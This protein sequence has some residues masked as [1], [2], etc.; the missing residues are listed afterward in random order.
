VPALLAH[1]RPV[2]VRPERVVIRLLTSKQDGQ[3]CRG[4]IMRLQLGGDP[5]DDEQ[6]YLRN[7]CR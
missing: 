1:P 5:T 3:R 2:V 6:T 7:G 4:I